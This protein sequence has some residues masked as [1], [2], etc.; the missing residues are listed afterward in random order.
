YVIN[1]KSIAENKV[2]MNGEMIELGHVTDVEEI[3]K[4]KHLLY[5]HNYFTGS[6]KA[7]TALSRIESGELE[8]IKVIPAEYRRMQQK[9]Q[10]GLTAERTRKEA[11]LNAFN[12]EVAVTDDEREK[13]NST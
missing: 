3:K 2:N 8:I 12:N 1:E 4:V 10:L 9:I 11:E 5:G 13:M 7:R 6:D